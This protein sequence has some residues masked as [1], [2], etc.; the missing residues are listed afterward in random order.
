MFDSNN[1]NVSKKCKNKITLLWT[2]LAFPGVLFKPITHQT[3]EGRERFYSKFASN[4]KTNEESSIFG[5]LDQKL[6]S[7]S[8]SHVFAGHKPCARINLKTLSLSNSINVGSL[9]KFS[10]GPSPQD[11]PWLH[12]KSWSFLLISVTSHDILF[13]FHYFVDPHAEQIA[14]QPV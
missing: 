3:G 7:A 4:D 12:W 11:L 10:S 2:V 5:W 14:W 6:E 13:K 8:F 1:K 9:V